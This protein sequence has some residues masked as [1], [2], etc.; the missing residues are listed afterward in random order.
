[1]HALNGMSLTDNKLLAVKF[2]VHGV[3]NHVLLRQRKPN[4][5]KP[6]STLFVGVFYSHTLDDC[7]GSSKEQA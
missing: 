3:A 7:L 5:A 1:V 2:L 4:L 6:K